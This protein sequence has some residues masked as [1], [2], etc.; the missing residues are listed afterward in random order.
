M[1]L[2]EAAGGEARVYRGVA[3]SQPEAAS[4]YAEVGHRDLIDR[5]YETE[6]DPSVGAELSARLFEYAGLAVDP[7]VAPLIGRD[8]RQVEEN[9]RPLTLSDYV[10]YA[11]GHHFEALEGILGFLMQRP[12]EQGYDT[13]RAAIVGRLSAGGH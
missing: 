6:G 13:A 12:G 1:V 4:P 7:S 10:N 8:G 3:G 9:G 11:A 5:F 2:H